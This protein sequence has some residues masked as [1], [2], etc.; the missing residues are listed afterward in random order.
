[1]SKISRNPILAAEAPAHTAEQHGA[2][3][4]AEGELGEA[5]H[6]TADH[7]RP[8][9]SHRRGEEADGVVTR[10]DS[11]ARTETPA[12]SRSA[13]PM[14]PLPAYPHARRVHQEDGHQRATQ[15]ERKKSG[16]MMIPPAFIVPR[17]SLKE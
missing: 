15:Y 2:Q 17:P 9:L 11:T 3:Q 14:P 6:Q 13:S 10:E 4:P 16:R 8:L 7:A 5:A 1:M 12:S